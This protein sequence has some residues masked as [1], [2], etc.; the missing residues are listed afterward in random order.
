MSRLEAAQQRL[1]AAVARLDAAVM[2][3]LD[4]VRTENEEELA[5]LRDALQ[6]VAAERDGLERS[7]RHVA[8]RL[9]AT[10]LRLH[11]VLAEDVEER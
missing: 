5:R 1:E 10:I 11:T 9:D 2:R 8:D 7:T 4:S 3:R 6:A